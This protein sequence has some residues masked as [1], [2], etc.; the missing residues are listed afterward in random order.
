MEA[1]KELGVSG[2]AAILDYGIERFNA[3]CRTSVM[4]YT[5]QWEHTIRRA[6]RWVDFKNDYKT[7]NASYM[8]SV[9][10]AFKRLWELGLIYEGQR[11]LPYSW[12]A[13]TPVSNFETRMDNATREKQDPAI[14]V[15]FR[16]KPVAADEAPLELWAWT[17]TPWTLPSNLALA[18][19]PTLDYAV[20]A[21]DGRRIAIGAA[22]AEKYE[23][24]LAGAERVATLTGAALAGR[25]YEPLFPYFASQ[26]NAFR[27]LAGDFVEVA[28]GTGVVHMAPGFGEDDLALCTAAGI[29]VV[30]PVDD[31][32]K[33]TAEI[34]DWAGEHVF[35]ANP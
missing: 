24:E 15:R 19:G 29:A 31:A 6:G 20:F 34:S 12:A 23:K 28:E 32:G 26:P 7:M 30:V 14:T 8:E 4:R 22:C 27:V 2:R 25:A 1:E 11:V 33:Y 9:I 10:W 21:K 13:Q 17:T 5:E 35:D 18:V 16:L 3:H